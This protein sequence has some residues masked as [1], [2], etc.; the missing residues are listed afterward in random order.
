MRGLAIPAIRVWLIAA[1]LFSATS[2]V[3][4]YSVLTHEQVVDIAWKDHIVPVLLKRYPGASHEQLRQAHAY[5]YGGCLIQDLGYYPFGNAFFTDLTHYVRSGDFVHNLIVESSDLN[6]YAFALGALAHYA[7]DNSGHPYVNQAVALS[8]PN[9]AAKYGPVVTYEDDPKAHIQTEFGFDMTQVA[10]NR[11]TSE[12][13]HDFIGFK[14]SKLLLERAFEKTYDLPLEQVVPHVD[15]AIGTF[16]RAV[17]NIIPKMTR[18]ALLTRHAE[19]VEDRP[20]FNERRFLYNLSRAEYER[21]WGRDYRRPGVFARI[22]AFLVRITPKI[23]PLRALDFKIPTTETEELYFR[24]VNETVRNYQRMLR[25]VSEG[26]SELADLDC[27][28]G[29]EAQA[30]EYR[31]SNQTYAQLLDHLEKEGFQ[32]V[33]PALRTNILQFFRFAEFTNG[34][35][36]Q[37]EEWCRT[38]RQ[39]HSL[40]A[41]A[42]AET[43]KSTASIPTP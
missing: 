1:S 4:A 18:V 34:T 39:L 9:L 32:S 37:R 42:A 23:G 35:R 28:T 38:L 27:D 19:V 17:S 10:K 16:R 40:E 15:L 7:G 2:L 5:A 41:S 22:L 14:V 29:R 30:G 13:Y 43:P 33:T 8:F 21:E 31:L 3:Q 6:E 12:S 25:A 11:Y 24:S 26:R 36:K 20:N